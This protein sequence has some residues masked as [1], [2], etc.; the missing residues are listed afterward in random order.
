MVK[1][2]ETDKCPD[3]NWVFTDI[4]G[5]KGVRGK[6][7]LRKVGEKQYQVISKVLSDGE[8][9]LDA[10]SDDK[11]LEIGFL[12][13]ELNLAIAIWSVKM[14]DGL[15]DLE[16]LELL[17]WNV[18]KVEVLGIVQLHGDR[19]EQF[20]AQSFGGCDWKLFP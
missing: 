1:A 10:R 19:Q 3:L 13:A 2:W 6:D 7:W 8:I 5:T 17:W 18:A 14:V 4:M 12:R 15:S 20:K 9:I 11:E 16:D